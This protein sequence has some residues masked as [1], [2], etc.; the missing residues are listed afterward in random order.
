MEDFIRVDL[1]RIKEIID[2]F[3][4]RQNSI[5]TSDVI[6]KYCG[7]FFS[8]VGIPANKSF[9]AQFGKIIKKHD[10]FLGVKELSADVPLKDDKG[11][12]TTASKWAI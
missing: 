1:D 2:H 12:P 11:N 4:E 7:G 5:F 10:E 9:N 3:R 6:R 8:N